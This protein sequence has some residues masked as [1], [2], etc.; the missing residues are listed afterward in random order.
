MAGSEN[1]NNNFDFKNTV[2]FILAGLVISLLLIGIFSYFITTITAQMTYDATLEVKKSML[3]ENV[4]NMV[5]YLDVCA[6]DYL[7]E[8]PDASDDDL[9]EAMTDLARKKIYSESHVDGTYMWVQ[10]VL[11]YDGGDDYAIR[12]IHPNLSDTEGD[13]LSTNE[14]NSSGIYAYKEE[15][16]GVK[17]NGSVFLTYDF[18]KLNSDE[19]TRKV[20]YS[21]LYERFDWIVCMGVNLDDLAHYQSQA[22]DNIRVYRVTMLIS[23]AVL[24]L[25]MLYMMFYLYRK[26]RFQAYEKITTE[27]GD[28][29]RTDAVTGA[30]SRIHGEQLLEKELDAFKKGASDTVILMMDVDF[31][32]K[33]N[34]SYGHDIGDKVLRSFTDSVKSAISPQDSIV[35][36]GGD[37]FL[38]ILHDISDEKLPE[39]GDRIL[40]AVR[41]IEI[42]GLDPSEQITSSMGFTRFSENDT[43]YNSTLLRADAA[44]YNAKEAGRNN[45]KAL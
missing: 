24:W 26:R 28:K 15:L 14:I 13:Y 42:E 31:F 7:A 17:E 19:V 6:D 44:L 32:K 34:D 37:E 8:N 22:N 43:D 41:S 25:A 35:R 30:N 27:L 2:T 29:L 20:T 33:F 38:V 4:E 10:K 9:E 12:L 16:D 21:R 1:K 5:S 36:W 18:K 40:N 3:E 45:W 23:I 39:T 11:N